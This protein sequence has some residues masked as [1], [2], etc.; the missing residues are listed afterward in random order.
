IIMSAGTQV[1]S[2]KQDDVT[3]FLA[4]STHVGTK[5]L[6]NQMKLYV[7]KRQPSGIHL[8]NLKKTWEKL[9]LAARAICAIENQADIYA[10]STRVYGQ[11]AVLKYAAATGATAIAGRFTPGAF[12]NQSQ[13]AFREPRLLIITDPRVDHQPI[14]ESS[15]VNIPVI[16][17]CNTDSPVRHVDIA[18][19]CNNK[20]YLSIGL[21]WWML[22][23]EVLRMRGTILREKPWDVMVDLYFYRDA[24]ET[25]KEEQVVPVATAPRDAGILAPKPDSKVNYEENWGGTDMVEPVVMTEVP[26]HV[27]PMTQDWSTQMQEDPRNNGDWG[28][29]SDWAA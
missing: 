17:F 7:Y 29:A 8:I 15:Y 14:T 1:L 12:T 28:G 27:P 2:I 5:S 11:R 6:D 3:K 9:L 20:S 18:I 4:C 23:R 21:M 19:P 16:A 26:L 13:G 24:E 25:E 10:V 22:A